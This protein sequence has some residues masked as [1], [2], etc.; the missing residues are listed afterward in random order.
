LR[1]KL[2]GASLLLTLILLGVNLQ[3]PSAAS[4]VTAAS[5]LKGAL[6]EPLATTNVTSIQYTTQSSQTYLG[7]AGLNANDCGIWQDTNGNTFHVEQFRGNG[8]FE[9]TATY[10]TDLACP[11][12][13]TTPY[14]IDS[15][16]LSNGSS[17]NHPSLP[18]TIYTCTR[19]ANPIVKN[20]SQPAIWSTTFNAT[21]HANAATGAISIM[22]QYMN[23]DWTWDVSNG[24]ITNCRLDG[25]SPAD[26][27]LTPVT[28]AGS[29]TSSTAGTPIPST[30]T[31]SQ[32][33]GSDSGNGNSSPGQTSSRS[34]STSSNSTSTHSGSSGVPGYA[35]WLSALAV[36]V[37]VVASVSWSV[38]RKRP[39][40]AVASNASYSIFRSLAA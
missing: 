35:V 23:Q 33:Q 26:F 36:V 17:W 18:S 3:I 27:T 40:L 7:C 39:K 25:M 1:F 2:L 22:G 8:Y 9:L 31:G 34:S 38:L 6:P 37:V 32:G 14:F 30:S 11:P 24:T 15:D 16:F 13:L 29:S 20:C 10:V 28:A 12:A 4:P 21:V 5:A 19:A